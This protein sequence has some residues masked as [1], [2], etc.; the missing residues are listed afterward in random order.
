MCNNLNWS[1][2]VTDIHLNGFTCDPSNDVK[3]GTSL[4][5]GACKSLLNEPN[6]L[7]SCL[8]DCTHP[9][10]D[11]CTEI[12]EKESTL[13]HKGH[14]DNWSHNTCF[15]ER[16]SRSTCSESKCRHCYHKGSDVAMSYAACYKNKLMHGMSKHFGK[17]VPQF[18]VKN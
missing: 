9:S 10:D 14:N 13:T 15:I 17:D 16:K 12:A 3:L 4:E 1:I 8:E 2:D 18:I 6:K 5:L 11:K 7:R